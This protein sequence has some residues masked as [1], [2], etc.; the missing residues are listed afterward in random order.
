MVNLLDIFVKYWLQWVFGLVAAGVILWAKHIIKLEKDS[1]NRTKAEHSKEMRK[2]IVNELE[3]KIDEVRQHSDEMDEKMWVE[4]EEIENG[5]KGLTTGVLSLQ[6]KQF[7]EFCI[8][9]LQPEHT[10]TVA[11]YEEFEK[12]YEVY[13]ALGGNHR[14]DA[15]HDRVVEKFNAQIIH[16]MGK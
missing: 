9:L 2:E 14:G 5:V 16:P 10:I 6:G 7:K 12:E 1:V 15:L 8:Y 4:I 11:E 13:K 3:G